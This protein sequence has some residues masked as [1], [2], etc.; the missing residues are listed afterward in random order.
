MQA[1]QGPET[2]FE[3][4][5]FVTANVTKRFEEIL[6]DMI[7]E[8]DGLEDRVLAEGADSPLDALNALGRKIFRI[9][10][11]V[12]PFNDVIRFIASDPNL[13]IGKKERDALNRASEH[14]AH[15]LYSLEDCRGRAQLLRDQIEGQLAANMA[16][17]TYN[18]TIVATVFLPLTFITGLLGINIAGIPEAHN[19]WGFWVVCIVLTVLAAVSW[20][21][22]RRRKLI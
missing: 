12:V 13:A 2:P 22:L 1:G 21:I 8:T 17:V 11:S 5:V 19:P 4:L 10:R 15:H 20:V 3:F 7:E 14:V 9:R 6:A 16:R 18:L